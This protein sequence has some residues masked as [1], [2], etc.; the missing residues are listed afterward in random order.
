M[1]NRTFFIPLLLLSGCL[2]FAPGKLNSGAI[3][4]SPD[5]PSSG[6]VLWL[7]ANDSSTLSTDGSGKVGQWRDKSGN[8]NHAAQGTAANQAVLTPNALNSLP[9]VVFDGI[10]D[11]FRVEDDP[12]LRPDAITLIVVGKATAYTTYAASFIN[13]SSDY[14][15]WNDGYGLNVMEENFPNEFQFWVNNYYP[16][17]A[18]NQVRVSYGQYHLW[19]GS[20]GS[21]VSSFWVDGNLVSTD[22]TFSGVLQN[23]SRAMTIGM[24]YLGTTEAALS[25]PLNGEIAEI[26]VY[27]R[28][29]SVSEREEVENYLTLK[30]GL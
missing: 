12:S 22:L 28:A 18:Q 15:F 14:S 2:N 30:W 27:T 6:L 13:K 4:S 11:Y 9:S 21:D 8:N 26:I 1:G 20:Y 29:L 25:D 7:D 10:N 24:N 23:S 19:T 3:T 16:S 17:T 5:I